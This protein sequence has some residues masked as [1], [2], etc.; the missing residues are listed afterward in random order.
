ML[1][2]MLPNVELNCWLSQF[3]CLLFTYSCWACV[4]GM[5]EMRKE[6]ATMVVA[7]TIVAMMA[8]LL[9]MVDGAFNGGDQLDS[10]SSLCFFCASQGYG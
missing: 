1:L 10:S 7:Y 6:I 8:V 5:W 2:Q 3:S 9:V 4:S